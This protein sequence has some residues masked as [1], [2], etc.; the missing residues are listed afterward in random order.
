M[1]IT[2]ARSHPALPGTLCL[3]TLLLGQQAGAQAL[4]LGGMP[5]LGASIG[6]SRSRI[7]TGSLASQQAGGGVTSLVVN[8]DR[9]D[10]GFKVYGGYGF[11]PFIALE[12]GYFDLGHTRFQA[13]SVPAGTLDG[14]VRLR[15]MNLD[16]V[17][18]LPITPAWSGTARVGLISTQAKDSFA[19]TGAVSVANS[20]IKE[21]HTS[22]KLGLGLQVALGP[23]L[24]LRGDLEHYRVPDGLGGRAGVN[25]LSLGLVFPLGERVMPRQVSYAPPPPPP[26]P[27]ALPPPAPPPVVAMVTPA[28]VVVPPRRRVSFSA[29]SLFGFDDATLR[30]EGASAL[31]GFARELAG[32]Q[33][34]TITVEGHTDR[35]GTSA[36]NQTLSQ[37][38]ADAVKAYL[39]NVG[40]VDGSKVSAVGKSETLPVTK[41][42]DCVGQQRNAKLIACLQPDR[43]VEIEVVGTR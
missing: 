14:R 10:T 32:T 19:G 40:R 25:L 22:A 7:D 11:N 2:F 1:N 39:V 34:D 4:D 8:P 3:L 43:R 23:Q 5:Y 18:T 35:L 26:P 9:N 27:A 31:D 41:P 24:L 15:G 13:T 42:E 28:P 36:Y 29:E 21:R 30:P 16:L 38:R 12:G 33:F 17:G 6:A 20:E 37:Q